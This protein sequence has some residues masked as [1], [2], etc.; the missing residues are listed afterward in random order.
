MVRLLPVPE[1][2]KTYLGIFPDVE[3]ACTAVSA[4]IGQG[5]V[6]AALEM[7]DALSIKAVQ[8]V[9]DAGYPDDAGAVLPDEQGAWQPPKP[10]IIQDWVLVLES[11]SVRS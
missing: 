1:A 9:S 8:N 6:P 11:A 4:V 10:P 2:V 5:I 7:I 3:L